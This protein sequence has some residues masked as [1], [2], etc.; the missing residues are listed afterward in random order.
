MQISNIYK[1][2][3]GKGEFHPCIIEDDGTI[4][5]IIGMQAL[6]L[7]CRNFRFSE[8]VYENKYGKYNVKRK[9]LRLIIGHGRNKIIQ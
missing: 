4:Y 9:S 2:V 3:N 6:L 7:A 5:D 8:R 1:I